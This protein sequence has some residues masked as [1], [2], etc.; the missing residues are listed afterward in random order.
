LSKLLLSLLIGI[1]FLSAC[2]KENFAPVYEPIIPCKLQTDNPT[3]RSYTSDAVISFTCTEKHCGILP[4]S[5][6]NYWIYEDSIFNNGVFLK[7]QLDTLRFTSNKKTITDGLIW[8]EGNHY[9]GL[10]GTLYANDS[11]FYALSE[12]LFTPDMLDVKK[13]FNIPAGDSL[14]YLTSFEDAAA[15][16]RTLKLTT[17]FSTS[18]GNFNDCIYFEKNARNYRKEQ[19][20]FKP[21]LGVVKFI[22]EKA[23]IGKRVIELQQ[24]STLVGVHIE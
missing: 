22:Y 16:G 4:L 6:K 10:P 8:W 5:S 24:I 23:P 19:V 3:G 17:P 21:G 13:E 12:R 20:F 2:R 7:V 15:K 1:I 14:N 9:I 18:F 11:A